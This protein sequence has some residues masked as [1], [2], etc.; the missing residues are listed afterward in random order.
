MDTVMLVDDELL[1]ME[2]LSDFY[3]EDGGSTFY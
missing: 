2:G 1:H 3:P